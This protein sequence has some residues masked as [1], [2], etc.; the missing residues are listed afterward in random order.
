[1]A[2]ADVWKLTGCARW[3]PRRSQVLRLGEFKIVEDCAAVARTA[4]ATG[5][6]LPL[7]GQSLTGWPAEP[8]LRQ[9]EQGPPP[10]L[11]RY[12][13][14]SFA[15]IDERR[16]VAQILPR[17]NRVADWLREAERFSTAA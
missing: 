10:R 2:N 12:G 4:P 1:M 7:H 15:C 6:P 13:V 11:R 16:M 5:G 9:G 8:K 17:W 14:A 3:L